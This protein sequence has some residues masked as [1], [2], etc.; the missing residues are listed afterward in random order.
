MLHEHLVLVKAEA[1]AML[2]KDYATNI[3]V[4]DKIESQA[5]EMAEMMSYGIIKQFPYKFTQYLY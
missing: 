5:L 4:Y 2:T 3:K 1:D